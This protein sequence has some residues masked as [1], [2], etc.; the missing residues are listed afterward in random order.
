[1]QHHAQFRVDGLDCAEEVLLLK[2]A[3]QDQPG[4]GELAFDVLNGRM[5]V[6]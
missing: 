2:Q 3:I 6:T 4:V 1:M 5:T